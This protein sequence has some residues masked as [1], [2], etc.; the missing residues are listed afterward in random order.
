M[1]ILHIDVDSLRPD[2]LGC[3]GYL[4]NT[5]PSIDA[6]ARE[7]LRFTNVYASDVPCL[8]SRTAL[9]SARFGYNTGVV[10]HGGTAA[11][12]FIEGS[13]RIMRDSFGMTG[14]MRC[15]RELGYYT[16]TI[17]SFGERHSAWHWY[18]GFNEVMN[19]GKGG[20][21]RADEVTGMATEWLQRNG[22][23][24][25]WYLHVNY[26]DP[27]T[28]YTTPGEYGN[29]FENDPLPAFYT[30]AMRER[31]WNGYGPHCAQEPHHTDVRPEYENLRMPLQIDSMQSLRK[32]IDGYDVGIRY[33]DDFLG[34]L[35]EA[36]QRLG[37]WDDTIVIVSGDHG[38]NLGELNVWG[39]HQTADQ[40]TCRVPLIVRWPGLTDNGRVD[41]RLHYQLDLPATV[42]QLLGGAVP[43][44]W[45]GRSFAGCF[46]QGQ[47]DSAREYL[48]LSQ[49]AWAV[50]RAVRWSN[51][52]CMWS[53][54]TGMKQLDPVMLFDLEA[55]P[56][57]E[58]NL[59]AAR[60]DLVTQASAYLAEWLNEQ[61]L[62]T[63]SDVDPLRTVMQEG[64]PFHC[65]KE[66]PAYIE[67]LRQTGR[68]HFAELLTR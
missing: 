4:R 40:V 38:E 42:L 66:L 65:R 48:V 35:F 17:S 28:P 14:W 51:Y 53:Y 55:D 60:G 47:D 15:M 61:M 62:R 31:C 67:R 46:G 50:Q 64:G 63:G 49:G 25:T 8:P 32:W 36:L 37:V 41:E 26:W 43:Q 44:N 45:D 18:A 16:A 52:L 34:Q 24:E 22:H 20:H 59:A 58:N 6:L 13:S 11:Q 68:G 21:E 9:W 30:E 12:P 5:S 23:R 54:H 39:D 19:C 57:E 27:H 56:H 2:H 33:M 1:R 10:N 3:Y 29:P 7:S